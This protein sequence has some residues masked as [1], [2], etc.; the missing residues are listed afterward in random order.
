M[1][2][3]AWGVA[4]L[5]ALL[6]G[7]ARRAQAQ[8]LPLSLTP[9]PLPPAPPTGPLPCCGDPFCGNEERHPVAVPG[10]WRRTKRGEEG[11]PV[12]A[13]RGI[14]SSHGKAPYGTLVPIDATHAALI[15][16]HCHEPGGATRPWGY[17]HGVTLLTRAA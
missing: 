8:P 2:P 6:A 1:P 15:E 9:E 13:A 3:I 12:S 11:A 7:T 5:L 14:L 16:Q 10:G 17:H 4:A